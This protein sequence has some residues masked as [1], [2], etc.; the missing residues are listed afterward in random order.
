MSSVRMC[1]NCRQIFSERDSGWQR[2]T[3]RNLA[4]I[5]GESVVQEQVEDRCPACAVGAI[6]QGNAVRVYEPEV[7]K[8]LRGMDPRVQSALAAVAG[9]PQDARDAFMDA[10]RGMGIPDLGEPAPPPTP[11]PPGLEPMAV[12]AKS[13][14]GSVGP[15]TRGLPEPAQPEEETNE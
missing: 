10:A 4:I 2:G 8:S 1:D 5:N 15:T 3:V 13:L 9:L 6:A 14:A 12:P 11:I 7:P